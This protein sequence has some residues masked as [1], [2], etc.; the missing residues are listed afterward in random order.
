MCSKKS[1]ISSNAYFPLLTDNVLVFGWVDSSVSVVTIEDETNL[2]DGD[3]FLDLR[4]SSFPSPLDPR[5][6]LLLLF[7][8]LLLLLLS[9]LLL[10]LLLLLAVL[11]TPSRESSKEAAD[12]ESVEV[13]DE[14]PTLKL[15]PKPVP[16]DGILNNP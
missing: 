13:E 3:F 7:V 10:L 1:W 2:G 8:L 5:S 12:D 11:L 4:P 16:V 15:L 6:S 14:E 9:L